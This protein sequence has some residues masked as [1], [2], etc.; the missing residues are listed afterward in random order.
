MQVYYVSK[1]PVTALCPT[2]GVTYS[3]NLQMNAVEGVLLN[4]LSFMKRESNSPWEF[5]LSFPC[6]PDHSFFSQMDAIS[7]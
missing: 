7:I 5:C 4:I 1:N 3:P 2:P 6:S